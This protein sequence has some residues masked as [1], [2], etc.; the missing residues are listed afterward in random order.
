VA[1]LDRDV[2]A[3]AKAETIL[4]RVRS[5]EVD[6]LVGTQ[7][8]T[9][10]HDLPRVT[11]VGVIN[12]DAALS[13]PDFRAAERAFQILVQ[14][15]GRAGRSDRPGTVIIQTRDPENPAIVFASR[16]DVRG[17]LERE[18]ADRQELDYPPFARWAMVRIDGPDEDRAR[19][20][21]QRVTEAASQ[22][23]A[24]ST[25]EVEVLPP[26]PAPLSRLQGRYRFQ[27]VLR[28]KERRPLRAALLALLPMREQLGA[29]IRMVIDVDPVKMM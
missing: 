24:V 22:T 6:I 17:F 20:A 2:A 11:L 19:A 7:M 21:A 23:R 10:G 8:V 3:G 9:K 27:V 18:I 16:H 5:G 15:A 13:M 29:A 28:A 12:A 25:G 4:D 1:R 26:R 14:V